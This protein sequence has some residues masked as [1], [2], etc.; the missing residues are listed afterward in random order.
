MKPK[1]LHN[2]AMNYSFMAKKALNEGEH[3]LASKYYILAANLESE[4][5]DFYI[6][7]S[8]LEPTR[9][10]I[11]RSAAFLNIK[12]GQIET[13]LKY[14]YTG[15]LHSQ[16]NLIKEQLNGALELA[17]SLRSQTPTDASNEFNY[18]NRLKQKSVHYI[19]EPNVNTYSSAVSFQMIREFIDGYLKSVKAYSISKLRGVIDITDGIENSI[20]KEIDNLVNPLLT[21]AG[22]GSFKFS[23]ANDYLQRSG[24]SRELVDFK[25]NVLSDYHQ[26]IF[27]NPLSDDDIE[28]LKSKY[29]ADGVD[30]IFRPL[31]KIKSPNSTYKVGYY[32]MDNFNK[33]FVN[34]IINHQKQKLLTEKTLSDESISELEN[35]IIHKG[36]TKNGKNFQKTIVRENFKSFEFDKRINLISPQDHSPI[37]L[38]EEIL[39]SI[40][41]DSIIGFTVS[42]A[43]L[44]LAC[45]AK[46]YDIALKG[47]YL[48]FYNKVQTLSKITHIS[49]ASKEVK[50]EWKVINRLIGNLEA[51]KQ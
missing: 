49:E 34:R 25:S 28:S 20:K 23:I 10:I 3:D 41:F 21:N 26:E 50:E 11:I 43:D 36:S 42:F 12:A 14:I 1:E 35:L 24:E 6:D 29:G 44:G 51:F 46:L 37:L 16:D 5:A 40:N 39:I 45:T 32:D 8:D 47:F 48:E 31:T 19:I 38:L 17:I 27:I 15:L 18:L 9:S 2:Q 33:I 22:W 7:K 30:K 4:V 13:A